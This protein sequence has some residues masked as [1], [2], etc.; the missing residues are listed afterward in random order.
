MKTPLLVLLAGGCVAASLTACTDDAPARNAASTASPSASV[1]PSLPSP[2][3]AAS[4]S[5]EPSPTVAA[6]EPPFPADE[7][8]DTATASGDP[9]TVTAVR[10]AR[11]DGYDRVV[12]ELA[13]GQG[14]PGWR[15]GYVDAARQQGS[16]DTVEVDGQSVLE[17]VISGVGY[18]F[19]TGQTEASQDLRPRDTGVVR[20]VD[21]QGTYEGEFQAFVGLVDRRAFRVFRLTDPARVVVDV[22]D[23]EGTAG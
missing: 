21:L 12:F 4:P 18:P 16:G 22:A 1:A 8:E 20:E 5:P 23:R 13:G 3:P 9:L 11:Q 7:S 14:V 2:S 6:V 19:D 17:V 15:V 10:A